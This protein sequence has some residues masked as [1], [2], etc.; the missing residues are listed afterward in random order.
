M[1]EVKKYEHD[2]SILIPSLGRPTLKKVIEQIIQDKGSFRLQIIVIA[3]GYE[4]LER[5]KNFSFLNPE[6]SLILNTQTKGVS[7]SLNFGLKHASGEYLMFFSDDDEWLSGKIRS[8]IE[9]IRGKENT[10]ICFQVETLGKRGLTKVRPSFIPKSPIDPLLY[11]YGNSPFINNPRYLSLT[12][13]I[14]P[15][16]VKKFS[17]PEDLTSREDVVWLQTV[18]ANGFDIIIVEGIFAKVEIGYDRTSKRDS[19]TEL[20]RWL[21]WL[22]QNSPHLQP[23]FLFCH[24]LRP[25]VVS[26]NITMGLRVLYKNRIWRFRPSFKGLFVFSFLVTSGFFRLFRRL[27]LRNNLVKSISKL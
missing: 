9:S 26:T 21:S 5:I 11:C 1:I 6:I 18:Y 13:F 8:S 20:A 25:Y 17:F 19:D 15:I 4:A 24:F 7:G 12:S 14:A 3:D 2:I 16:D 22:E 23:N 10:C 27:L